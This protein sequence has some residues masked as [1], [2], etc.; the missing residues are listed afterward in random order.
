MGQRVTPAC[1][2]PLEAL[3]RKVW[4]LPQTNLISIFDFM[5]TF[6]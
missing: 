4:T 1:W 5:K 3:S 6:S 2:N